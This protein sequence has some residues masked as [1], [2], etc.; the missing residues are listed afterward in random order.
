MQKS[1]LDANIKKLMKYEKD[2]I[3]DFNSPIQRASSQWNNLQKSLLIH[4][5]LVDGLMP[6]VYFR[7]DK[8]NNKNH[9]AVIEG[10][11]RL[12][13]VF[14][15]IDGK[16]RLHKKTP[17]VV[18]DDFE[19]DVSLSEFSDLNIDLQNVIL[20]YK[21]PIYQIEDATDEEIEEAFARLNNGTALSKI[22][23]SRPKLGME[24]ADWCNRVVQDSVFFQNSLNLT[25]AM[26]RR[27]DDFLMLLTTMMLL[28]R[29]Y[30]DGF[31]I[32]T[33]A[34]ASECVRFAESIRGNYPA[35][36]R[37]TIEL[38][39]TYL[40][41][42]FKGVQYK[43]LR[44]NNVPIIAVVGQVALDKGIPAED[45]GDAIIKFF[46]GDC[47]EEY[48]EASGSGNVKMV[49]VNIRLME[50]LKAVATAFPDKIDVPVLENNEVNSELPSSVAS[51]E[52]IVENNATGDEENMS[53]EDRAIS[54]AMP[55]DEEH[56]VEPMES[57]P[58]DNLED[59]NS[60][61]DKSKEEQKEDN[62]QEEISEQSS[63]N[64][65]SGKRRGRKKKEK[66]G[67]NP[68]SDGEE[69][70]SS[71][72][73]QATDSEQEVNPEQSVDS[74][75]KSES[76][77]ELNSEQIAD[78]LNPEQS[79][80]EDSKPQSVDSVDSE[81]KSDSEQSEP[82]SEPTTESEEM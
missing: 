30:K 63:S 7:K 48:N 59:N 27:E 28:E 39:V 82:T 17:P 77:Q 33:S 50:L 29:N 67:A 76:S 36:K 54:T 53:A 22:Q 12:T 4:S 37:E 81:Q 6:N 8:L 60:E 66:K 62:E 69:T 57:T 21:F 3:L 73:A 71:P 46:E 24:L 9:L 34:S 25:L 35:D 65:K 68:K 15:F 70:E 11:Q 38:L 58:A 61:V 44:K 49:N 18:L 47:T 26:L 13:T 45:Y 64:K 2:G 32:K 40:D 16:F 20:Q 52:V 80:Q 41:E 23:Q 55:T 42:A 19:Y 79:S 74:E 72:T 31:V 56:S 43:F 14:E 75:Q 1:S 5:M 10:K 51:E 78:E